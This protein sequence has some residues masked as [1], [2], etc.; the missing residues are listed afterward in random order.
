MEILIFAGCV[1]VAAIG[2]VLWFRITDE[3]HD[4]DEWRRFQE[5][6]RHPANKPN[7]W[8]EDDPRRP[9]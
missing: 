4:R 3:W 7:R 8:L 2:L 9:E 5:A 1:L 6:M